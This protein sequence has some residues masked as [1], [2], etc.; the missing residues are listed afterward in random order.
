MARGLNQLIPEHHFAVL[1]DPRTGTVV[2]AIRYRSTGELI[3]V[4]QP[5]AML[6]ML[7]HLPGCWTGIEE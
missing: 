6:D 1:R 5:D 3:D 7:E 4:R 2:I